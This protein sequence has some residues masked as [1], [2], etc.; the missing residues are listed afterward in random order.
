MGF[1]HFTFDFL[2]SVINKFY[3]KQLDKHRVKYLAHFVCFLPK[4]AK[5][6][7]SGTERSNPL[8]K[9]CP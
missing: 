7:E 2:I 4:V 8:A 9:V 1:I 3:K 6:R 5:Q